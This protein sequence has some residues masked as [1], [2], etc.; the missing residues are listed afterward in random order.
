MKKYKIFLLMNIV[1]FGFGIAGKYCCN[2][3]LQNRKVKNIF[4]IDKIKINLK[5]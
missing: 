5:K 4:V 2:I 1:I 3:L